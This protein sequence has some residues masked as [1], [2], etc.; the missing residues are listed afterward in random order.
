M[1]TLASLAILDQNDPWIAI[2]GSFR[3][4]FQLKMEVRFQLKIESFFVIFLQKIEEKI[5]P[6]LQSAKCSRIDTFFDK[7]LSFFYCQIGLAGFGFGRSL[8]LMKSGLESIMIAIELQSAGL[9]VSPIA[10]SQLWKTCFAIT[11]N[12]VDTNT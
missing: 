5:D 3:V 7:K 2:R 12:R 6:E 1:N 10:V 9:K 8:Q 4:D 11:R